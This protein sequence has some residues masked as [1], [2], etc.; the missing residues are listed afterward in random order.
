MKNPNVIK[1]SLWRGAVMV[2]ALGM[3]ALTGC[4]PTENNKASV[5]KVGNNAAE[6]AARIDDMVAHPTADMVINPQ[7]A[8]KYD[9]TTEV[10][11]KFMKDPAYVDGFSCF[12]A[13]VTRS[14]GSGKL[15]G[16]RVMTDLVKSTVDCGFVE[17]EATNDSLSG[18][19]YILVGNDWRVGNKA[20]GFLHFFST[21]NLGNTDPK[22]ALLIDRITNDQASNLLAV[23]QVLLDEMQDAQGIPASQTGNHA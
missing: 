10:V 19:D 3:Q 21:E 6:L 18:T 2:G 4:S 8:G 17:N 22:T 11:E 9:G 16:V 14:N 20:G 5:L 12:R 23:S 13:E 1:G 15:I 7:K